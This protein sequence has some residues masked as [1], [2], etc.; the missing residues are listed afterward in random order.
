MRLRIAHTTTYRYEPAASGVIQ[1]LRMTP[2]SHDGQYVADW[3]IDVS[4][5]S[6]LDTHE[7]AFGNV[8]H[9]LTHG[10][11]SDL[12]IHCEGLI[13]TQDTGG[14]LKGT[15]ERFPPNLFLRATPLTDLNP[16]MTAVVRELRTEAG[17]DVLGFLHAL[18]AQIYEHMTFDEDPTNSATSA[19]EAFALKRGVCQDY[20]HILIAC[21]RAGGVPARFVSGHFLRSDGMVNQQAGHAWAEAFVP[22]LGWVGFDAANGICT[23]DAHARVAIGLDYLGAAPVRGTRYGGGNETLTVAVKVDQAGR[24]G[25]WQSH[26]TQS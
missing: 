3:Q 24:P 13:E 22:D 4:T 12:T 20:A 26:Q 19:A 23:T 17:G 14:V 15:D 25:Q 8:T 2:G 7:D 9:V 6:R 10:S 18:M 21:A 16:A 11:I 5:D 1:I